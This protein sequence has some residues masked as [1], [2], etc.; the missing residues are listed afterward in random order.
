[1]RMH[2]GVVLALLAAALTDIG[3]GF[4]DGSD[5]GLPARGGARH[6]AGGCRAYVGAIQV[7]TNAAA[8]LRHHLLPEA[9]IGADHAGLGAIAT[10]LDAGEERTIG[11]STQLRVGFNHG[12]GM[13]SFLAL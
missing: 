3:A 11:A 9:G 4:E 5:M 6:D 7:E 13:H 10:G 2:L 1:M 12:P 8:K